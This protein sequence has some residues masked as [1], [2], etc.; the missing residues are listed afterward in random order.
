MWVCL[1]VTAWESQFVTDSDQI[2]QGVQS[3]H[4]LGHTRVVVADFGT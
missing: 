2:C 3:G 4:G 1:S